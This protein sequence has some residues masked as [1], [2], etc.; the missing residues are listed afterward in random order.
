M[1]SFLNGGIM[2]KLK[3]IPYG[4]SDFSLIKPENEYYVD[5]TIYIPELEKSK[6]MFLIRPRRFGK[7][8]FLS[9]LQS[10]YDVRYKDR[11]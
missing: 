3:N 8:L 11:F 4:V 6:F 10:Y 9:M 7:S 2:N 5:K 1:L